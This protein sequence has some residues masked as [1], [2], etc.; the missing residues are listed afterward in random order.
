MLFYE[1]FSKTMFLQ[2]GIL[3][4]LKNYSYI[5]NNN[6][7]IKSQSKNQKQEW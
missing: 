1:D 3:G 5:V 7:A 4:Q 6:N 2:Y